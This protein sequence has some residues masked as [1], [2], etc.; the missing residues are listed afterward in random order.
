MSRRQAREQTL[1]TLYQ[2]EMNPEAG[3]RVV[4]ENQ[5][6]LA[7]GDVEKEDIAFFLGLTQGVRQHIETLDP[8]IQK[9]LKQDWTLSRLSLVDRT[10]LR[11]AVYEV[12]FEQDIPVGASLNE[13]VD[14]AKTFSTEESARFING[15]L[16]NLTK[17]LDDIQR[18]LSQS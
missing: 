1:Q 13:A 14:L 7:K 16:G 10:V 3:E 17:N 15:V 18:S 9:Y 2:L 8:I 12:L 4:A 5:E 6:R 11:M